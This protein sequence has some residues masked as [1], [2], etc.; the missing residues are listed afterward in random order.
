MSKALRLPQ[1]ISRFR[2]RLIGSDSSTLNLDDLWVNYQRK[3]EFNPIHNHSEILSFVIRVQIPHDFEKEQAL[4]FV[5]DV[6]GVTRTACFEFIWPAAGGM[7]LNTA[8]LPVSKQQEGTIFVFPS[9]LHHTVYPYYMSDGIRIN[10][11]GNIRL[12]IEE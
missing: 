12:E 3:Y 8:V 9:H 4:E 6:G 10:V 1:Q 5:E 2:Q 7:P 11:A